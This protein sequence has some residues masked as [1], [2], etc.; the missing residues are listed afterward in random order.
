M[1]EALFWIIIRA[2]AIPL[3]AVLILREW[4]ILGERNAILVVAIALTIITAI[5]LLFNGLKLI[6]STLMMR[7]QSIVYILLKMTIQIAAVVAIWYIF[8]VQ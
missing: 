3:V 2:A 8:S 1:F 6:G 7:G 4:D 5:S